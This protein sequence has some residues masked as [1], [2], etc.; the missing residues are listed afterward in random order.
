[1]NKQ[2]NKTKQQTHN[3]INKHTNKPSGVL[4]TLFTR[5]VRNDFI[6]LI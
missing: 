3:E 1:M 6:A 4:A 5:R 2:I